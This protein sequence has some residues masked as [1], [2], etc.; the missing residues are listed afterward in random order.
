[1]KS[2]EQINDRHTRNI[3][4]MDIKSLNF[5]DGLYFSKKLNIKNF[6]IDTRIIKSLMEE[7]TPSGTK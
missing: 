4:I 1:M 5:L 2:K 6:K 7:E 3:F